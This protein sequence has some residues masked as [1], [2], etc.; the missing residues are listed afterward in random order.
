MM[1]K[2]SLQRIDAHFQQALCLRRSRQRVPRPPE[3]ERDDGSDG[4][5]PNYR[6]D[7]MGIEFVSEDDFR[8]LPPKPMCN[9]ET[10]MN[11]DETDEDDQ[12][13]EVKT[14]GSLPAS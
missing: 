4:N 1:K 11:D 10:D 14:A 8:H 9:H 12:P 5:Q 2:E 13:Y 3:M 7:P 6:G